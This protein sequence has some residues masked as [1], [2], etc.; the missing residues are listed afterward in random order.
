MMPTDRNLLAPLQRLSGLWPSVID[1]PGCEKLEWLEYEN[2]SFEGHLASQLDL[3]TLREL[4][5][6]YQDAIELNVNLGRM[7]LLQLHPVFS[8]DDLA[9][10]KIDIADSPNV[11]LS[12][13]INKKRLAEIYYAKILN[14]IPRDKVC[15]LYLFPQRFEAYLTA[16]KLEDLEVYFWKKNPATKVVILLPNRDIRLIGARLW[17]L[18]GSF[19][20]TRM[21][22]EGT[23]M[24]EVLADM[25]YKVCRDNLKWQDAWLDFLTPWHLFVR[26]SPD[27]NSEI[28]RILSIHFGNL[29]L[30]YTSDLT[31][32]HT[33]D[34]QRRISRYY[35]PDRQVDISHATTTAQIDLTTDQL[36]N[37]KNILD[38]IYDPQWSPGDRITLAQQNIVDQ[39]SLVDEDDRF[40]SIFQKAD[41]I[42][43][44]INWHWETFTRKKIDSYLGGV[45]DLEE[46]LQ[47]VT[48]GYATNIATIQKTLTDNVLAAIGALIGSFIASLFEKQFNPNIFRIGMGLYGLYILCFPLLYNMIQQWKS[49]NYFKE[50]IEARRE[51]F[52]ECLPTSKVNEI[53]TAWKIEAIR[54][55]FI[56][57]YWWTIGIYLLIV[58]LSLLAAWVIPNWLITTSVSLATPTLTPLSMIASTILAKMTPTP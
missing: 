2:P 37:V 6:V 7:N 25:A 24:D 40:H 35:S 4:L 15:Y 8:P 16:C 12:L 13:R 19:L 17:I 11:E 48:E 45:K 31:F 28:K 29:A 14:A 10:F 57:N 21:T 43:K 23:A 53:W 1:W 32:L 55:R 5:D 9:K 51:R 27:I 26:G 58:V 30:L 20:S 42:R 52:L 49:S 18:G 47:D 33:T 46:Y 38:W 50:Q 56:S 41:T 39:L 22:I 54:K 3:D 36:E 34:N 44:N